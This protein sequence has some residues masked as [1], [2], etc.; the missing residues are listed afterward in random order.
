VDETA[1]VEARGRD[2][3]RPVGTTPEGGGSPKTACSAFCLPSVCVAGQPKVGAAPAQA[4]KIWWPTRSREVREREQA[5]PRTVVY[6]HIPTEHGTPQHEVGGRPPSALH[7]ALASGGLWPLASGL[8]APVGA[9]AKN[10]YRNG[11]GER[12]RA[13]SG[14]PSDGVATSSDVR[15]SLL[16]KSA[17][18]ERRPYIKARAEKCLE[19]VLTSK[20]VLSQQLGV[21]YWLLVVHELA[22]TTTTSPNRIFLTCYFSARSPKRHPL[23]CI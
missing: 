18:A 11:R 12:L 10:T 5:E 14:C 7:S 17:K 2:R 21:V 9:P 13:R 15:K 19:E 8:H 23:G 16:R 3:G 6:R 4:E 22:V 20:A 1:A